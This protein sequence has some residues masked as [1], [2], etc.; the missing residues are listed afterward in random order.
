MELLVD[1]VQPL[2][3]LRDVRLFEPQAHRALRLRILRQ[4]VVAESRGV[5]VG[6][7]DDRALDWVQPQRHL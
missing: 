5:V 4:H 2:Q 1:L 6:E 7:D 3:E